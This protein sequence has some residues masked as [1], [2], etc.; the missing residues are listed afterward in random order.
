MSALEAAPEHRSLLIVEEVHGG[1]Q[2]LELNRAHPSG[3]P[4]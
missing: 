3:G 4:S 2:W 1:R